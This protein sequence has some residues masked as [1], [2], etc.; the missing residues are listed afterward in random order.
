[1]EMMILGILGPV[2]RCEWSLEPWDEALLSTV[3]LNFSCNHGSTRQAERKKLFQEKDELQNE[4]SNTNKK[5]FNSLKRLKRCVC[6]CCY[7]RILSNW[8][9]ILLQVVFLGMFV[10]SAFWGKLCDQYGRK[11]VN[12]AV[13]LLE[14]FTTWV[15]VLYIFWPE[16]LHWVTSV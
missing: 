1:M 12:N 15:A 14:L 3:G 6:F 5:H 10:S 13:N 9:C 4:S 11:S 8:V 2:S 16:S 7:S